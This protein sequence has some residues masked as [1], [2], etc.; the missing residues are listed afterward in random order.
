MVDV[1]YYQDL[2]RP[3]FL[4]ELKEHKEAPE[5]KG[6]DLFRLSRLSVGK[7]TP[8]QWAFLMALAE[9]KKQQE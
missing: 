1:E 2:P 8:G 9:Q 3:L 4:T 6:M 7:V 5:L